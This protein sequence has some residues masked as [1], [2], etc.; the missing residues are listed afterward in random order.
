[1]N[2]GS[3]F[4]VGSQKIEPTRLPDKPGQS[5][6]IGSVAKHARSAGSA[7]CHLCSSKTHTDSGRNVTLQL[8][9]LKTLSPRTQSEQGMSLHS[10]LQTTAMDKKW[11]SYH[12]LF[13][14][15][16]PSSNKSQTA[17]VQTDGAKRA[18][19]RKSFACETADLL[20]IFGSRFSRWTVSTKPKF[21]SVKQAAM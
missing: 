17:P 9:V 14:S 4:L 7:L 15:A 18:S 1:M 12:H 5:P 16:I 21:C 20:P 11:D 8:T 6:D 13:Q 10:R 3:F 19:L 2:I